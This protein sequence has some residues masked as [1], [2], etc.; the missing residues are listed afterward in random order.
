MAIAVAHVVV[1]SADLGLTTSTERAL[2]AR[3]KSA[4]VWIPKVAE[5]QA[6][7]MSK[8]NPSIPSA[9]WISIAIAG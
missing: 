9:A 6:T 1:A 8:P 4:A 3:M 7:F 2:P 5:E